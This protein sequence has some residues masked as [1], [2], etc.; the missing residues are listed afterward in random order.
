MEVDAPRAARLSVPAART[1][2]VARPRLSDRLDAGLTR[3]L[4]VVAAPA[5]SGKSTVLAAWARRLDPPVAW[6]ALEAA[7]S[8]PAVFLAAL[9]AALRR[10]PGAERAGAAV[11]PELSAGRPPPVRPVVAT[12]CNDLLALGTRAVLVLD[13]T[14]VIE[15]TAVH[16]A[17]AALI[18]LGEGA[19]H[20]VLAGRGDPALPLGRL[21][22]EQAVHELRGPD[23]AFTAA[24]ARSLV[25][26][27]AKV[28]LT[29]A[30]AAALVARTEGWAAGIQ[31]AALALAQTAEPAA[32]LA[33]FNGS[34]RFVL[35]YFDD[36]VIQRQPRAVHA[37][38]RD[39][40]ILDRLSGPLCDAVAELPA[41]SGAAL[42]AQLERQ[43]LF[44]VPLD[45][46]GAWYRY[47][48][49]FA[50]LLRHRLAR[51][52]ADRLPEL[53]RRAGQ[54]FEAQGLWRDAFRHALAAG[55]VEWAADIL[56]TAAPAMLARGESA[57]VAASVGALDTGLVRRR[58]RL[59]LAMAAAL[60][61]GPHPA[62]A[63]PWLAAIESA[64]QA[65]GQPEV[66][67]G[68][69]VLR[70]QAAGR[71]GDVA[72]T[73]SHAAV[74]LAGLGA[75]DPQRIE[76]LL[77]LGVAHHMRGDFGPAL[78]AFETALAQGGRLGAPIQQL[79]ALCMLAEAHLLAGRLRR[80]DA[81]ATE[82]LELVRGEG[83]TP[84][85]RAGRAY[86]VFG[87]VRLEQNDVSAAERAAEC[88]LRLAEAG[89]L[90]VPR[91]TGN[92]LLASTRSA[93][94]ER[95]GAAS[96][97]ADAEA[98][99]SAAALAVFGPGLA[100]FRA[101]LAL[102]AGDLASARRWAGSE[103]AAQASD[104]SVPLAE[105]VQ[106]ALTLGRLYVTEGRLAQALALLDDL[107]TDCGT[108]GHGR[109]AVSAR[110]LLAL[111][112]Q[113]AGDGAAALDSIAR[114]LELA[115]REGFV[116]SVIAIGPG[117]AEV[118][119]LAVQQGVGGAYAGF[120]LGHLPYGALPDREPLVEPLSA[121]EGEVLR[122]MDAG[123]SNTEIAESLVISVGTVKRHITNI[124]GK[125]GVS[126]RTRALARARE[127][128]WLA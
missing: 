119:R 106:A 15:A 13:D 113:R 117:V 2:E 33:A 69:A 100:T 120:L 11:L 24:E 39:T 28:T 27:T 32:Q 54:W 116:R 55:A 22:L 6:L 1:G 104:R 21:R 25:Q 85:P 60:Q 127:L 86:G 43:G 31:A 110:T 52:W 61:V 124:H 29:P 108:A 67:T 118:L 10:L 38:L 68:V 8:D 73:M 122:L 48:Q 44:L 65:A 57:T 42:L 66:L 95:K 50:D 56:E 51:Q 70:T 23:L 94:G 77:D 34:H 20:P 36:E 9:I 40:A 19:V 88:T 4:S 58:P 81:L 62:Q 74:A 63:E 93:Q 121:R 84:A 101:E 71:R 107:T 91:V 18:E 5:G 126:S 72:A 17:L 89:G 98:V 82:A 128:G 115:E 87:N 105:R 109:A 14:Q 49:L 90:A 123:Q 99:L 75:D 26:H 3:R 92:L 80:A 103:T 45:D 83:P 114:V 96:A 37:F 59:A 16:E 35:D 41:G 112:Q 64:D 78:S 97:V 46:S 12:L 30:E 76:V 47:H 102:D 125:L 79:S 111:A 7:D 53:H